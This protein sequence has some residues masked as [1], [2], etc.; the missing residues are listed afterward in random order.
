MCAHVEYHCVTANC[1]LDVNM[2]Y[3]MHMM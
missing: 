3:G 2:N 1:S